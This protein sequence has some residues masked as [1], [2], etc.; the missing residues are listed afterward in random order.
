MHDATV[1]AQQ[2][3]D[4]GDCFRDTAFFTLCLQVGYDLINGV[5]FLPLRQPSSKVQEPFPPPPTP[6]PP[7]PLPRSPQ[8]TVTMEQ[9]KEAEDKRDADLQKL[10]QTDPGAFSG[11]TIPPLRSSAAMPRVRPSTRLKLAHAES[12]SY[13][14]SMDLAKKALDEQDTAPYWIGRAQFYKANQ[15]VH[16]CKSEALNDILKSLKCR[17]CSSGRFAD[18]CFL[19]CR[20]LAACSLCIP[21]DT[22]SLDATCPVCNCRTPVYHL[23]L[24]SS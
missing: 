1:A 16:K 5:L 19:E 11:S 6:P 24:P 22:T 7:P 20:H 10:L 17:K 15:T 13:L 3:V 2:G 4:F 18:V 23:I 21:P 8:E 14:A 12:A 9:V